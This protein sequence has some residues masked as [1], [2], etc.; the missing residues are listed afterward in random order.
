MRSPVIALAWEIWRQNR[1]SVWL[2]VG[3]IVVCCLV[4]HIVPDQIRA[5]KAYEELLGVVNGLMMAS[6]FLFLFGVF[7]YTESTSRKDWTGFPYRLF[8]LPVPTL[9]LVAFPMASGIISTGLVYWVWAKLVFVHSE[10]PADWWFPVVLGGFMAVYQTTLWSLAGFRIMRIIALGLT[11]P[12]FVLLGVLPF[13]TKD[14]VGAF[15]ASE[16]LLTAVVVGIAFAAFLTAWV[17][18][19]RQRS[20]G[21]R[22]RNWLPTLMSGVMDVLPRRRKNFTSPAAAQFWFEWRRSGLVLPMCIGAIL[23]L[24][25]PLSWL[26]RDDPKSTVLMLVLIPAMPLILSAAVGM[27]F[28]RPDF[29]SSDNSLKAFLAVRPLASGDIVVTKMKVAA[30]SVAIIWS[31]VLTFLFLWLPAWPNTS[32]LD[33][34]FF[35]FKTFYPHAWLFIL[36]LTVL[37]AIMATW[38]NL[39]GGLWLGLVGSW[40]PLIISVCMRVSAF[41]LVLSICAWMGANSKWRDNHAGLLLSILGWALALAVMF[42]LWMAVFSWKKITPDRVWKYLLVWSGGTFCFVALAIAVSPVFDIY[43]FE[44]LLVLVAFLAFPLARLGLAPLSLARNRH[45]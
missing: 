33:V 20:G 39:I 21:G 3:I 12:I 19:A 14:S 27:A 36:I 1:R 28:S 18:V 41:V 10:I 34:Y 17:S 35:E 8:V 24:M 4:N 43:R 22:R 5:V 25:G 31:Q 44:H 40:K 42:K 7:N 45:R 29:W 38:R 30:L 13:S 2:V 15:W 16:K 32:Q 26:Y 6:S 23:I 11:G 9:L 37:G